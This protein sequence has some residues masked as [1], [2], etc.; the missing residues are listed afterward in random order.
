VASRNPEFVD[1]VLEQ[2]SAL[3]GVHAR[4]MFGGHGIYRGD[5]MF[6]LIADGG[7]YFKAD[8]LTRQEFA[9][10]GLKAFTYEAR[11]K[12]IALQ[13]YAAPPEVFDEREA[14]ADWARRGIEAALRAGRDRKPANR[15]RRPHRS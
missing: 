7:L 12:S 11:G 2:M 14:M 5:R 13:Y 3:G 10:R 8:E 15:K 4:K 1:F 6:A 9:A